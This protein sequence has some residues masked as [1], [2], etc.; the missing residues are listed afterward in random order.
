M[1]GP[2]VNIADSLVDVEGKTRE[3]GEKS[4]VRGREAGG[5]W[6]SLRRVC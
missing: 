3:S 1:V 6:P 5:V 4:R 2:C